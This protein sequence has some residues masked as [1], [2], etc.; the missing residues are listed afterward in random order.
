MC[1][2]NKFPRGASA[3][4][5]NKR[6]QQPPYLTGEEIEAQRKQGDMSKITQS[7]FGRVRN[8]HFQCKSN[9]WG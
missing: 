7:P 6:L 4:I 5:S 2:S 1:V 8:G 3:A 9:S